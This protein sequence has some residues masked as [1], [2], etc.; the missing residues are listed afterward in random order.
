MTALPLVLASASPRRRDL[1]TRLGFACEYAAA[2]I[3]ED[4]IPYRT[5][6]E[7]AVK[8]AYA[9]ALK[10]AEF[11]PRALIIAADT[12]V[13]LDGQI[14][15]KPAD[16]ADAIRILSAIQGRTHEVITAVAVLESGRSAMLDAVSTAVTLRALTLAE[17][18]EYVDTGEPMDKAGAY[19]AQ[20]R[21]R[22][23]IERIDGDY[24]NVVGLPLGLLLNMLESHMPVAEYR[25]RLALLPNPF[26]GS[27]GKQPS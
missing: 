19:A 24:F 15:P 13:V 3:D 27:V 2:D 26:D 1:L 7:Y 8:T 18:E 21:G 14:Y 25:K 20:G 5:P 16:R 9:K 17:I 6:R 11:R 10:V 22:A 4:S 12:I 23:L